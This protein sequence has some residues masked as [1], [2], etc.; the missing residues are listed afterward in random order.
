MK[1]E[2]KPEG[3]KMEKSNVN[4][5]PLVLGSLLLL[6]GL[7]MFLGIAG[8]IRFFGILLLIAAVLYLVRFY[9]LNFRNSNNR[10]KSR[11][12]ELFLKSLN[13]R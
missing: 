11:A 5:N 2:Y 3:G 12:R 13:R 8:S 7:F 6:I 4:Y 1:N 9:I 10:N